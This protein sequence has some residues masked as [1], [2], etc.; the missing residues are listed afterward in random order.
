MKLLGCLLLTCLSAPGLKLTTKVNNSNITRQYSSIVVEWK[1]HKYN[2]DKT[3][4]TEIGYF[5]NHKGEWQI[6]N[7]HESVKEVPDVLPSHIT[8][9]SDAFASNKNTEIKGIE[10]WDTSNVTD[11]S[12]TFKFAQKFNQDI[13]NWNTSQVT[14]MECMFSYA[15]N[16]NQDIGNWNISSLTNAEGIFL[17]AETFNRDISKWNTSNVTTMRRMFTGASKFNQD[18]NTKKV[19]REDGSTYIAWDTSNVTNMNRMFAVASDFN[20]PLDKWNT[21]KVTDMDAM[22]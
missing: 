2:D 15:K 8:S 13:S 16:F 3:K 20:H 12:Y 22:F 5:K 14:S 10:K 11:M 7:F 21:S 1:E 9:L 4:C 18:I 17:G 19:T 6:Q